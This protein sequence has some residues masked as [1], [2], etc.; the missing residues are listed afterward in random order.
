M[1]TYS[2]VHMYIC[3]LAPTYVPVIFALHPAD[4]FHIHSTAIAVL[5]FPHKSNTLRKLPSLSKR[6]LAFR[7]NHPY[8]QFEPKNNMYVLDVFYR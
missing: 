1:S 3:L 5:S 6:P 4:D 2:S 8:Y 7:P